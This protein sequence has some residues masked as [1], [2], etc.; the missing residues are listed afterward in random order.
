[1]IHPKAKI[2]LFFIIIFASKTIKE[3]IQ[4]QTNKEK[5]LLA[6]VLYTAYAEFLSKKFVITRIHL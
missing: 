4:K 3:E 5:N 2:C 1:M 6:Y